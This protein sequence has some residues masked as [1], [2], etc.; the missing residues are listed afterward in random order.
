[1]TN[2][3]SGKDWR[4]AYNDAKAKVIKIEN[5]ITD[6]LVEL[7]KANPDVIVGIQADSEHTEIKAKSIQDITYIETMTTEVRLIYIEIIEKAL[8]DAHPYQQGNLFEKSETDFIEYYDDGDEYV[9]PERKTENE[10]LEIRLYCMHEDC[11]IYIK[12]QEGYNGA[13]HA[14]TGQYCDLRN[15]GFKCKKHRNDV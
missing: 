5:Q 1:M 6:R 3:K 9:H 10:I 7:C 8:A 14:E 2:R 12:G 11:K 15:Q 4:K 13:F